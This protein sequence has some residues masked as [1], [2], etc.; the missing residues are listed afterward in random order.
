LVRFL[1][2]FTNLTF[3]GLCAYFSAS[4]VQTFFYSSNIERGHHRYPLQNWPRFLQYHHTL[5]LVTVVTFRELF[6]HL[7]GSCANVFTSSFPALLVTAV[8]WILLASAETFE[9]PYSCNEIYLIFCVSFSCHK[10]MPAFTNVTKHALNSV[11]AIFEI[12]FTNIGPPL[13]VHLPVTIMLLFGY[14]GVAYITFANQGFYSKL[15]NS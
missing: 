7:T 2:Y 11:F 9:T 13:W 4:A 14:L 8:Y 12:M 3:I 5:L 15:C 10:I 1:S 6:P